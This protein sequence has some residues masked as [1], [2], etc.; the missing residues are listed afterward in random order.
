ME[1]NTVINTMGVLDIFFISVFLVGNIFL[2]ILSRNRCWDIKEVVF[3]KNSKFND[4]TLVVSLSATLISAEMFLSNIQQINVQGLPIIIEICIMYPIL[5]LLETFLLVPR[6]VVTRMA[7]SWFEYIN[8]IYGRFLSVFFACCHLIVWI[9]FIIALLI[10]MDTILQVVFNCSPSISRIVAIAF[11]IVLTCYSAFGGLRAVTITDIMQFLIFF[12]IIIFI[13]FYLW[14][15]SDTETHK[16]FNEL[17]FSGKNEK[18]TWKACFGSTDLC[19]GSLSLWLTRIVPDCPQAEY[20]RL[21]AS[22]S[23]KKAKKNMFFSTIIIS[24]FLL[25]ITFIGLQLMALNNNL[26]ESEVVTFLVSKLNLDGLKGLFCV[27]L[28][29]LSI[30][31]IDSSLNSCAIVLANDIYCPLRNVNLTPRLVFKTT[32]FIGFVSIL[33]SFFPKS[34]FHVLMT[35]F[36]YT[37]PADIP[38]LAIILGIKTHK[39]VIFSGIISGYL[40]IFIYKIFGFESYSMFISLSLSSLTLLISHIIWK[41]YFKSNDPNMYYNKKDSFKRL[42][43]FEYDDDLMSYTEYKLKSGEWKEDLEGD[44]E[45]QEDENKNKKKKK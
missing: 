40:G 29:S 21:Y 12:T 19:I 2:G 9:G 33:I 6:I 18:L 45:E 43:D 5:G 26:K 44:L 20:Q 7:F 8:K 41:K 28:F 30:S 17:I 37:S 36:E 4:L 38:L 3:G 32:F 14:I 22:K 15:S 11:A 35:A 31:S 39:N 34:I 23:L 1:T 13:A 16:N 25:I 10:S 42:K 27:A 24:I